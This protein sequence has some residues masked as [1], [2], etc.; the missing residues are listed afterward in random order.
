MNEDIA[1]KLASLLN[2]SPIDVSRQAGR[3]DSSIGDLDLRS[4]AATVY[5]KLIPGQSHSMK[6]IMSVAPF[7]FQ[8]FCVFLS[9]T[10][11]GMP[12]FFSSS[13]IL[14]FSRQSTLMRGE[15]DSSLNTLVQTTIEEEEA[16]E[17]LLL[18]HIFERF[19]SCSQE[20]QHTAHFCAVVS[21]PF[22]IPTALS[23]LA[24]NG[25]RLSAHRLDLCDHSSE[26]L[27]QEVYNLYQLSAAARTVTHIFANLTIIN[28]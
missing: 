22:S 15:L 25:Y 4:V 23:M 20:I 11:K 13:L 21:D 24:A 27:Y 17:R 14:I 6:P 5:L 16:T 7:A 19:P 8:I 9:L 3:F 26:S 12:E 2:R 10:N 18:H 1:V 28:L